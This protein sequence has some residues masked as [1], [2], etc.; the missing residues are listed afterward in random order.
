MKPS[1][2]HSPA[3]GGARSG[4][5]R[6]DAWLDRALPPLNERKIYTL[7][8]CGDPSSYHYAAAN[9]LHVLLSFAAA[10]AFET[11]LHP[12]DPADAEVYYCPRNFAEFETLLERSLAGTPLAKSTREARL[13]RFSRRSSVNGEETSSARAEAFIRGILSQAPRNQVA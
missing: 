9:F 2:R 4:W 10:V 5:P 12:D 6:Y 1:S 7:L 11:L 13:R 3:G 8:A